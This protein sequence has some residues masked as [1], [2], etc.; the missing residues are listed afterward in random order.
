MTSVF[1]SL[2]VDFIFGVIVGII[3]TVILPAFIK[4]FRKDAAPEDVTPVDTSETSDEAPP[5]ETDGDDTPEWYVDW[6]SWPDWPDD[7]EFPPPTA[8]KPRAPRKTK[9]DRSRSSKT[10]VTK[11]PA[12]KKPASKK[13]VASRKR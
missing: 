10:P 7:A 4:S 2:N 13:R 9:T 5:S 1:T 11:K 12:K 6:D 3:G 8:K